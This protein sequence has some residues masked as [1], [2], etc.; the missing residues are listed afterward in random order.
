MKTS[1]ASASDRQSQ[2]FD[3]L[4]EPVRRWIWRRKWTAL[5]DIQERAIPYLIHGDD[6][7]II[8]A[9]TAGGKTEAAFLPLISRAHE[10]ASG[11]GFDLVYVGPLRALINDQF[12][13]LED[14]CESLEMP[15]YP[16]HGDIPRTVK[17]RARKYPRGILL[18]TPESLEA[19]FVLRGAEVCRLFR[20]TQSIVIDELHALLDSERGIH[21]RSLLTRIEISVGR[22][23]RRVGLSATLGDMTFAC[24]YLRPEAPQKVGQLIS[25]AGGPELRVQV[26][27]YMTGQNESAARPN[28]KAPESD[29][30]TAPAPSAARAVGEHIFAKLR[31]ENNLIFA[32]SRESVELYSDLLRGMCEE[33]RLPNEFFPHHA[34]LSREHRGD[35]E[36]R[37][38]NRGRPT[39]AVCTSTLELGID[40]GGVACIGQIG[41]PW[42]VSSLRQRLGRSGRR[43]GKPAVLRMYAIEPRTEANSHP[44]DLLHLGLVRSI[45]MVELL[46]EG[47][48]EPPRPEALHLST[49]THQILSVIA[50]RGGASARRLYDILC[51]RGPF[52]TVDPALFGQ[53]LRQIGNPDA[54]LIEQAPDGVL[55]LGPNGERIVESHNF[56]AVFQTPREY[57]VV[58]DLKEL[59]TLPVNTPLSPDVTIIFVG[60]RWRVLEVNDRERMIAVTPDETGRPPA[61]GGDSGE[62]HETIIRKMREL[63]L[64]NNLPRYLDDTAAETLS[65]A[66]DAYRRSGLDDTPIK[67]LGENRHLLAPWTGTVGTVSLA[68]VLVCLDCRVSTFDGILEVSTVGSSPGIL[69][70]RLRDIAEEKVDLSGLVR[71]RA[72]ALVFEKFHHYLGGNLL[73]L[74]A[75]SRRLRLSEV[76]ATA[77]RLCSGPR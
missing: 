74:D 77:R 53:L 16:W 63:L 61:F 72:N 50:E 11:D 67:P 31:G 62:I 32:G 6:D 43:P 7:L 52:R 33:K 5:R 12:R 13:R 65:S 36:K 23:I 66:R 76:P 60:R 71:G 59:G 56:Y 54:A 47:W 21:L 44:V 30:A 38:R 8:S 35:I 69:V 22:R 20:N 73:L 64:A 1:P 18:I 10:T 48:C 40:I 58:H 9:A 19:L 14:L 28:A 25:R 42:S 3:L 26:R 15:V 51:G 27:A 29:G 41:P 68:T 75:L 17:T 24:A 45:A 57:R 39:T 34:N 49:L 2:A 4:A 37:L 70:S 46:L 55:L